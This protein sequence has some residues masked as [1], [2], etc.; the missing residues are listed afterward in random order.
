MRN[1]P[2]LIDDS[3][4]IKSSKILF[5]ACL[6][7][8]MELYDYVLYGVM[9]PFIASKFFPETGLISSALLGYLSLALVVLITPLGSIFWGWYGDRFGKSSMLTLSISF[10]AIAS[11]AISASRAL[12]NY[13]LC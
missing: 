3:K 8:A 11:L 6:G 9:L 2:E 1:V 4:A 13:A 5:I 10:M 12:T 7:H